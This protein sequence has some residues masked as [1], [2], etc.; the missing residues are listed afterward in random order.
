[1]NEG[2]WFIAGMVMGVSYMGIWW[3]YSNK[4]WIKL[5]K[6]LTEKPEQR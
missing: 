1:M 3:I 6:K 4:K 2:T 5:C